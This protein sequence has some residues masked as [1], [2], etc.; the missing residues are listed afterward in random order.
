M[1]NMNTL[2]L[3]SGTNQSFSRVAKDFGC[4][5]TTLD[6]MAEADFKTD[7]LDWDYKQ[8]PQGH[9]KII[10]CSP[11]CNTFSIIRRS[12]IGR[13]IKFFGDVIVTKKML[14][15]DM[16]D[17]GVSILR[18][19]QEILDYFQPEIWFIENPSTGKMK[20][21]MD[22]LPYYDVDYCQYGFGYKK[23]TRIWTNLQ[24]FIPLRCCHKKHE[25]TISD[26]SLKERYSIPKP[27]INSLLQCVF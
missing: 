15:D 23:P 22:D 5:C 26:C 9:F 24:D 16:N 8:F 1:T 7:I 17:R 11:P 20:N 4:N 2:E 19:T 25:K 18:K 3:F 6:L 13:K 27:L 12:W 21:Y 14:D 10:W